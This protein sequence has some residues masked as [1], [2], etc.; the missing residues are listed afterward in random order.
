[1][2]EDGY[3]EKCFRDLRKAYFV[4]HF[5]IVTLFLISAYRLVHTQDPVLAR[6]GW[7]AA[8]FA[9]TYTGVFTMVS[10]GIVRHSTWA[11]LLSIAVAAFAITVTYLQFI[12]RQGG[13]MAS[14]VSNAAISLMIAGL[15]LALIAVAF[16]ALAARGRTGGSRGWE[17]AALRCLVGASLIA[18][19]VFAW[20]RIPTDEEMR[21]WT[22][23]RDQGVRFRADLPGEVDSTRNGFLSRWSGTEA[24]L[25]FSIVSGPWSASSLDGAEDRRRAGLAM[26]AKELEGDL[27]NVTQCKLGGKDASQSEIRVYDE[28][29]S[30]EAICA[31]ENGATVILVMRYKTAHGRVARDKFVDSFHWK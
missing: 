3:R 26:A 18:A 17:A 8:V 15:S 2:S 19:A 16:R 7:E 11:A 14:K 6:M 23:V 4:G 13:D 12:S 29:G 20:W 28:S 10:A 21:H 30:A 24:T 22:P 27:V 25:Q 5:F 9:I 31:Y 1:M